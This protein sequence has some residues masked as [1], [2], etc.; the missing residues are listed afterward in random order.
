MEKLGQRW[1]GGGS[2]GGGSD[3][4]PL[5]ILGFPTREFGGQEFTTDAKIAEFAASQNFPGILLQ[6]GKVKGPEAPAVWKYM[7]SATGAANPTWNFRGKFLVSKTG[8]VSTTTA[9]TVEDD[10]AALMEEEVKE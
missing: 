9:E 10:I 7:Q 4:S 6:L 8:V 5:V 3:Q 2:G 1:G